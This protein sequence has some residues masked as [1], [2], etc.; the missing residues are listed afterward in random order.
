LRHVPAWGALSSAEPDT[1]DQGGSEVRL[2]DVAG[3]S[4]DRA[5]ALME[6]SALGLLRHALTDGL[7]STD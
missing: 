3:L 1:G 6:W 4:Y 2:T 7:P 5:T